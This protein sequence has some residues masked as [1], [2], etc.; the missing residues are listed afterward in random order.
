MLP[1]LL[2]MLTNVVG[3]LCADAATN[4]AKDH[5]MDMVGKCVP[6]EAMGMIDQM[7][8]SDPS[9]PCSSMGELID[10]MCDP[11]NDAVPAMPP[12]P[13]MADMP[14][15]C[16]DMMSGALQDDG[17]Q[18]ANSMMEMSGSMMN[19]ADAAMDTMSGMG[20][21]MEITCKLTM[22]PSTMDIKI[23]RI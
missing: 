10:C 9:N 16:N 4:L 6:P 1:M 8:K 20:E 11:D 12:M 23:E 22:D 18:L 17:M 3:G 14:Q 2:P 13:S 15:M 7:V 5:V 19:A 21:P